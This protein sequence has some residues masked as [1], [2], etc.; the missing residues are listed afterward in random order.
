MTTRVKVEGAKSFEREVRPPELEAVTVL[1][2]VTVHGWGVERHSWDYDPTG[3]GQYDVRD[4]VYVCLDKDEARLEAERLQA[5][6]GFVRDRFGAT[7][8]DLDQLGEAYRLIGPIALNAC[9]VGG[10]QIVEIDN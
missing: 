7:E 3:Q 4:I 1:P 2:D 10:P 5:E 8:F 9:I 6:Q